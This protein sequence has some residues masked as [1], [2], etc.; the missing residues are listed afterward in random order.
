MPSTRAAALLVLSLCAC[1]T[2]AAPGTG[3]GGGLLPDGGNRRVQYFPQ[4]FEKDF[5]LLFMIDTSMSEQSQKN[6]VD[7]FPGFT[8][9]L[10]SSK[11]GPAAAGATCTAQD[12]SG[13]QIPN[14]RIGVVSSD[15][16]AG[17]YSF[18]TCETPGGDRG[19]LRTGPGKL[20][21]TGCPTAK[22]PWISYNSG[23][24]NV[25]GD[26]TD[27]VKQLEEAFACTAY[28]G[29]GGCGFEHQL[30]SVN[31]A[32]DGCAYTNNAACKV[33]PGFIRQDALLVIVLLTDEDDCSARRTDL[34]D[35]SQQGLSDPLGPLASFRCTEFGIVCAEKLRSPGIK[36]G[37]V[38]GLDW[39]YTVDRY[40]DGLRS[41][42]PPGRV[43]FFAIAGP[44]EPVEV[45]LDGVNPTL[46]HSC[47]S[48]VGAGDPAIRIAAV[49]KGFG[50]NGHFN[51]GVDAAGKTVETNVCATDYSPALRRLAQLMLGSI[52]I[53]DGSTC[54]SAPPLTA[55][56]AV[57]MPS[58]LDRADCIV[59][60][61]VH[62]Y[63][64]GPIPRCLAELF[65]P[66]LKQ[67]EC[68][69]SCPCWRLLASNECVPSRDG[70]P[71]GFQVMRAADAAAGSVAVV[72]CASA[73][74]SWG[75][76]AF[77]ALPQCQ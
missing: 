59:D 36:H 8:R 18:E 13:C 40:I 74:A 47:S 72:R 39:L 19:I 63:N 24:T 58:C 49:A 71:Y 57:V 21:P 76:A 27:P 48:V 5:D 46:K 67:N 66:A 70:S 38:P 28:L 22:D 61:M 51:E 12:P 14:L 31:R 52:A 20:A 11:L 64:K 56:G 55:S 26:S 2:R 33:N 30:E 60:E 62:S 54:L 75:S 35:P 53:G 43:T 41:L 45:G 7:N 23:T 73:S 16:G 34:F 69:A 77:A 42:K 25:K 10:R 4:S 65:D 6:L 68:G 50:G 1:G 17:N 3:D 44:P 9:A 29:S 15:L 32:L 37:C